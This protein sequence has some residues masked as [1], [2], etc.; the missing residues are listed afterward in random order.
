MV[1]GS[2]KVQVFMKVFSRGYRYLRTSDKEGTPLYIFNETLWGLFVQGITPRIQS[3]GPKPK[4][5]NPEPFKGQEVGV[6]FGS[7]RVWGFRV[8][9]C[10]GLKVE[11]R[12]KKALE[13]E[14]FRV[15]QAFR[16]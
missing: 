14:G 11:G 13:L 3:L 15:V 12:G 1:Q 5:L 6:F 10:G 2:F 9:R 8:E 16:V 7:S 4:P